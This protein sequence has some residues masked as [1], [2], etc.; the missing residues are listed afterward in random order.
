ML[1]PPSSEQANSHMPSSCRAAVR[2]AI[3]NGETRT[4]RSLIPSRPADDTPSHRPLT[5]QDQVKSSC[6]HLPDWTPDRSPDQNDSTAINVCRSASSLSTIAAL[7]RP[8]MGRGQRAGAPP[9]PTAVT[10]G[11]AELVAPGQAPAD[12]QRAVALAEVLAA[13]LVL[14]P[15]PGRRWRPGSETG[16]ASYPTHAV[17]VPRLPTN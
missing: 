6:S 1:V 10:T 17:C 7:G 4:T 13:A 3:V 11:A 16:H 2:D 12:Q 14:T 8:D 5:N 15:G 9:V